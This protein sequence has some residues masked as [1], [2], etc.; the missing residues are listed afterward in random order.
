MRG[1]PVNDLHYLLNY[2]LIITVAK[3]MQGFKRLDALQEMSRLQ[4]MMD[5]CL[6]GNVDKEMTKLFGKAIG[7][8][9]RNVQLRD[10]YRYYKMNDQ[11]GTW[12]GCGFHLTEDEYPLVCVTYE[13]SPTCQQRKE[14]IKA[15]EKFQVSNSEWHGYELDNDSQWSGITCDKPLLDFLK[16]QDHIISIQKYF[17]DKLQELHQLKQQYKDLGWK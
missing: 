15:M 6:D 10:H 11:T 13:V 8:S 9:N 16:D 4:H 14:V 12:V 1:R 7:W 17:I 5:E 2:G 3:K